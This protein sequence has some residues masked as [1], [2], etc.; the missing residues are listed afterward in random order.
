ML[1]AILV[2]AAMT[3]ALS[4][5]RARADSN[6]VVNPGFESGSLSPWTCDAGTGSVVGSPVHSGSHALAGAANNSDD[7]QCTQTV[8]VQPNSAY[9]LSA[10]V[11]GAYV[12]IGATGYSSTWTPSATSYQQLSTS[13]TTGASTTSVQIYLHGWYGQGTYYAD[14]VSLVGPGG[15]TQVPPVPSGLS[16][17]GTTSS[18]VSLSWS[19][20]TGATGYN[21]YRGG[22]KVASVTGTSYTDSGLSASTSYS[23]T[24]SA[25]NSAGESAQ[26]AAVTG[27]TAGSGTTV[28][29]TPGGLSVT[30]TT[31]SS[32]SLSWTASSGATGY[33]VYRGGSKVASV[34]GTSYTDSGLSASTTYSYAVSATNSAGE[35]AKS[36]AVSA[37][38]SGTGGTGGALP[39]HVL[40][41]YWQDFVNSAKPLSLAA[42]PSGYNLVAVAF[43][44]A[45]ASNPGGVTFS[46]DSGLS[47][48]L[49]GYTDAQ[50]KA[51]IATL[52]SR[53][54]KVIVSVGGQNGAISVGDTTSANNFANSVY[55]IMQSYGFDGVDIDLENGV[56]ATYMAQALNSLSAKAGSGLIITMAPQ[57][58]D[59]QST[60]M[61]YFQLALNIK[62]I[63]TISNTQ[64][65]NSGS[66][67]GCDQ[68]VYAEGSENFMTALACI[69]LQGGLRPDQVGL[70][71]PASGSAAG[72]GYVSPSLVN[73][74][75]DCLAA[76]TSCGSFVPPSTWPTIRGAMTWSIN[77]DAS[78]GWSFV[79]T[80]APHLAAM[81]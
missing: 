7:A 73:N 60:G 47:S 42:V 36:S 58:I 68:G 54:Q 17:T 30:G 1:A 62:N 9:T 57:T 48:A 8:S 77:W 66:M 78:N 16:V 55:G 27:T 15:Q 34:T 53:G 24:V 13:F 11:E 43:A 49:G 21:V 63:L 41:G 20:S 19:A 31:S 67:N 29:P 4:A 74:A 75:L 2:A 80:V 51:D 59:M 33:N 76:K 39:K 46:V 64:Y 61:A 79:N 45:D 25:T 50:F 3:V 81:P 10:Y 72:G 65:Y 23:Y 40:T 5:S 26:S 18:S 56:N 37:T 52:H 14:D 12:Y 32:V 35:S 69:Q 70:G 44:N 71:L 6:L 28:P 38:T 22:S